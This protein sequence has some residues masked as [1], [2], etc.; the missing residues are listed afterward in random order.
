MISGL[1]LW[2]VTTVLGRPS[3]GCL[4]AAAHI[5]T[6]MSPDRRPASNAPGHE[7]A[8]GWAELYA[9]HNSR[10]LRLD[11]RTGEIIVFRRSDRPAGEAI[12]EA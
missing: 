1:L 3:A 10:T 6:G 4:P 12:T 11:R 7:F 9:Y 8:S 2:A 5:S